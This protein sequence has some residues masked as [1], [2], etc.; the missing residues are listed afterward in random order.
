MRQDDLRLR[1]KLIGAFL[2]VSLT[3]AVTGLL[4]L[5]AAANGGQQM[6]AVLDEGVAPLMAAISIIGPFFTPHA[7]DEVFSS[8]VRVPPSLEPYPRGCTPTTHRSCW[9]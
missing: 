3:A 5:R 9:R 1:T 6:Q 4:G 2:A 7:Y 8:Y